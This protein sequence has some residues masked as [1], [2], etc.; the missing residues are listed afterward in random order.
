[1]SRDLLVLIETGIR[2]GPRFVREARRL[3]LHPVLLARNPS[4]LNYVTAGEVDAVV[5][6]T[7]DTQAVLHACT[8]LTSSDTIAGVTTTSEPH[9]ATVAAVCHHLGL[10]G[11]DHSAVTRCTDKFIQRERLAQ[12]GIATPAYRLAT[13]VKLAAKFAREIGLPVIV[14]PVTG[15]GSSGVRLCRD[16][17]EVIEQTNFLLAGNQYRPSPPKVLIEEFVIGPFCDVETL[18]GQSVGVTGGDFCELP[19]F[20]YSA[21]NFPAELPSKDEKSAVAVVERALQALNLGWGPVNTELRISKDGPVIIEVNPRMSGSVVPDLIKLASGLDIVAEAI[22]IA[23]GR[24]AVLRRIRS[25][26]AAVRYLMA[27]REGVLG[28]I[29]GIE[30]ALKVPDIVEI[31]VSA[32]EGDYVARQGDTRDHLGYVVAASPSPERTAMALQKACNLIRIPLGDHKQKRPLAET[33][34]APTA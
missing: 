7:G 2:S 16:T 31:V 28:R 30:K 12:A 32:S 26:T 13:D 27:D 6:D 18:N 20:T 15:R 19:Y 23:T 25:H 8:Q 4:R 33:V 14:K 17:D 21:F 11:P 10:P 29:E 24:A 1:M 34:A 9:V 3:G 5:V 22:K